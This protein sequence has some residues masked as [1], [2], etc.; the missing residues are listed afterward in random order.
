MPFIRELVIRELDVGIY[1]T[2]IV[3]VIDQSHEVACL[4]IIFKILYSCFCLQLVVYQFDVFVCSHHLDFSHTC[5]R[6]RS[7]V[8][9]V[10][11]IVAGTEQ[12]EA[13]IFQSQEVHTLDGVDDFRVVDGMVGKTVTRD[14]GTTEAL[15]IGEVTIAEDTTFAVIFIEYVL[16]D[17][18]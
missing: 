2:Y 14:V 12:R 10:D 18:H 7:L 8:D 1:S 13:V 16:L 6:V 5:N 3:D 9:F 17:A 11:G 15:G 4:F